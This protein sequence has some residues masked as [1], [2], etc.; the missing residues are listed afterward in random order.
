M[1]WDDLTAQQRE[2]VCSD[3]PRLLVTGGAGSGKTTVA[4]WCARRQLERESTPPWSRALFLTFTKAAVGELS[5]RT[6]NAMG[7]VAERVEVHTFHSFAHRMLHAFGRYV[8]LGCRTP[9][10]QSPPQEKLLGRDSDRLVYD[11]L[12]PQAL[13]ILRTPLIR[14]LWSRRWSI[15]ICDEFQ[16]TDDLQW[17]LLSEL[18]SF[19]RLALFADPN[20]MIYTFLAKRGVGPARL[21]SALEQADLVVDLGMPSH[22]DPT[23]VVPAM[24]QAVRMRDFGHDAVRVAI[25]QDKLVIARDVADEGLPALIREQVIAA[26]RAGASTVAICAH[27]NHS[28]AQLGSGLLGVGVEHVLVGLP[29]AQGEA[30]AAMEGLVRF[31]AG[32]ATDDEVAERLAVFLTSAVRGRNAPELALALIG[33]RALNPELAR[34][35]A[36]LKASLRAAGQASLSDLIQEASGAWERL[37]I[38]S[39]RRPWREASRT[40]MATAFQISSAVRGNSEI[41]LVRLEARVAELRGETLVGDW[42]ARAHPVQLMNFHQTKGREADVVILVYRADDYF[43][44]ESE[45]FP[46]SSRL[47]YVSLTRA[48]KQNIMILPSAPHALVAPFAALA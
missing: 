13:R 28:V 33:K 29:E 20:Q 22:R 41:F 43:G 34:R 40:F 6:S 26:R 44:H 10:L 27:S 24:A 4:L 45:P 21:E 1:N 15:V 8:G 32:L 42:G 9:V 18:A 36:A 35:L 14:D 17:E 25:E 39:G 11:D 19:S 5:A 2:A 23:Q 31:G 47:L 7:G 3:A 38:S 30:L 37:G 48:R 12:A 46:D 16:D